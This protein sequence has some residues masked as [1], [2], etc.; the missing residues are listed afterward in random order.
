MKPGVSSLACE[1][2]TKVVRR[3]H[4][5]QV[6]VNSF[7]IHVGKLLYIDTVALTLDKTT[8]VDSFFF[9]L[10]SEDASWPVSQEVQ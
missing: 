3:A 2:R 4:N 6:Q 9:L 5:E 7:K 10:G 8:I 1:K